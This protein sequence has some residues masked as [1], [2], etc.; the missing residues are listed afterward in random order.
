[1]TEAARAALTEA[2]RAALCDAYRALGRRGMMGGSSGNVSVRHAD[3]KNGDGMLISPSGTTP[4]RIEPG[5]LVATALHAPSPGASS[6]WALHA[7]LYRA[8]AGIG[9]VVHTHADACTALACLGEPLPA[10]HYMVAGFGGGDVR[11]APYETFGTAALAE[12][13]ATAMR[14]R[15]ACLLANH[16]MVAAG[17]TLEAAM[18][19]AFDLEMLARQYLLARSAGQ[20]RLLTPAQMAAARE[21]F[22]TY[23]GGAPA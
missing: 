18:A 17:P 1:M 20:P 14:N 22:R 23:G 21:R 2:A 9:A 8:D 5:H 11:C 12:A 3:D 4:E 15:T 16:G 10:F 19:A 7:A 6:E 13:A